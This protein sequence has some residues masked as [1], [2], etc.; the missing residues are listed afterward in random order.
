VLSVESCVPVTLGIISGPVADFS[1]PLGTSAELSVSG[2]AAP[3]QAR[4]WIGYAGTTAG[5]SHSGSVTIRWVETG[6]ERKGLVQGGRH[7]RV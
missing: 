5:D 2:N 3:R 6:Q 7:V 1:T 4:I